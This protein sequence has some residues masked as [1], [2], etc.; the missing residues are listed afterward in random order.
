[1]SEAAPDVQAAPEPTRSQGYRPSRLFL[2]SLFVL[3]AF[4]SYAALVK[5]VIEPQRAVRVQ[6]SRN[7]RTVGLACQNF[8]SGS[9][10]ELPAQ[11]IRSEND[12]PLLSWRVSLLPLLDN[13][14]LHRKADLSQP[15]DSDANKILR[16]NCPP[17]LQ[18]P[19]SPADGTLQTSWF[20]IV[21]EDTPFPEQ[22][23]VNLDDISKADG[24]G[25]TLMFVEATGMNIEWAEPKDIPFSALKASPNKLSG[26]GPST[27][28]RDGKFSAVFCDGHG[29]FMNGDVDPAVL[30]A[31]ATWRGKEKLDQ[32]F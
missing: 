24:L 20:T 12:K 14:V 22:G 10:A 16:E 8:A 4:A 26:K 6:A 17:V 31:L 2:L 27:H 23:S 7:V 11:A 19:G 21:G 1:M 3:V 5:L 29:R 32:K 13:A 25:N 28:R 30:R 18:A 15:W 9:Q